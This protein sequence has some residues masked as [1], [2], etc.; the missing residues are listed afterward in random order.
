MCSL[1]RVELMI[2]CLSVTRERKGR[3]RVKQEQECAYVRSRGCHVNFDRQAGLKRTP[4]ASRLLPP[5]R[6]VVLDWLVTQKRGRERPAWTAEIVDCLG[7]LYAPPKSH[8]ICAR[9][10]KS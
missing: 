1:S 9:F 8:S 4:Q 10:A 5:G 7:P 2:G 6:A 3:E